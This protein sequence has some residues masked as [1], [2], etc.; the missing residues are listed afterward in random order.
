[1]RLPFNAVCIFS[2]WLAWTLSN[3]LTVAID[4]RTPA[5]I[6]DDGTL[7]SLIFGFIILNIAYS[8]VYAVEFI[9]LARSSQTWSR[10][11]RLALFCIGCIIGFV[12]AG[13][14]A[15]SIAAD[16]SRNKW[17]Q[18]RIQQQIEEQQSN[19]SRFIGSYFGLQPFDSD[20]NLCLKEDG[21][22]SL[23]RSYPARDGSE[24]P[25]EGMIREG[26]EETGQWSFNGVSIILKSTS[27]E[28]IELTP[29]QA[30]GIITLSDGQPLGF[31]VKKLRQVGENAYESQ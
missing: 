4:E 9:V 18:T 14:G 25:D 15:A 7:S 16:I 17:R 19:H 23:T 2:A 1:M 11:A 30:N 8:L 28:K 31:Y 13:R 22:Y 20:I 5:Y 6:C 21:T 3:D 10:I 12:I 24:T 26:F 29:D 27:G